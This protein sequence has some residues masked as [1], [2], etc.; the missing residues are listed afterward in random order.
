MRAKIALGLMLLFAVV[1]VSFCLFLLL[2]AL[3]AFEQSKG[4]N[5]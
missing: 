1:R 4:T 3:S 2:G 5:I